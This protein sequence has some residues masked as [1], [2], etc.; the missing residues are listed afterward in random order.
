MAE[1]FG[2]KSFSPSLVA[3]LVH[4]HEGGS[5]NRPSQYRSLVEELAQKRVSDSNAFSFA[6]VNYRSSDAFNEL[7]EK[8]MRYHSR[9][10]DFVEMVPL[11][12][13]PGQNALEQAMSLLRLLQKK[14]G[15]QP[16]QGDGDDQPLPIFADSDGKV[17][18]VIDSLTEPLELLDTLDEAEEE[19][20]NPDSSDS[21]NKREQDGQRS[22]SNDL[23]KLAV[24]EKLVDG[25]DERKILEISR[26]LDTFTKMQIKPLHKQV[27]DPNAENVRRRPIKGLHELGKLSG[28]QWAKKAYLPETYF[29]YQ[30]LTG[31]L[32]VRERYRLEDKKQ[33]IL[34][35]LDGSGSMR[36]SRHTKATGVVMNRL[37]GVIDG[38]A[39][40][41]LGVFDTQLKI[42]G[43]AKTPEEA[44]EL[45]KKFK[46][47]NF[48]GGGTNIATA[49]KQGHE[50]IDKK[51]K[52]GE[53]LWRPEIVVLT[54]EDSSASGVTTSQIP[55]TT[56][57]GFA[58]EVRNS[59]LV[60]LAESTGGVGVENF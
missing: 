15:G 38:D 57:H 30:A 3:D 11:Q 27:V 22:G 23:Q 49:V 60:K 34:I 19:L 33:A 1:K 4:Y 56:V 32:P 48:R 54:D 21:E 17:G 29:T 50:F 20:L 55:G 41:Y 58:M 39:E 31:Q 42:V 7:V 35:L 53:A 5:F 25:T 59:G 8:M 28:S 26:R 37:K 45:I 46:K 2:V 51:M 16:S 47:G 24:A 13:F 6:G 12:Q 9:I 36:G 43:E 18:D 40:V 14:N 52:S 10:R 44:R